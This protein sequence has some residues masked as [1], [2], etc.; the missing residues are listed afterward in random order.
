[1]R[2][3]VF[4]AC[5][6]AVSLSVP[7]SGQGL[8]VPPDSDVAH[9]RLPRPIRRRPPTPPPSSYK[10]K[11]ISINSRIQDQVARTQ[12]TQKFVNTGSRQ[13]E[14]S[15][16]FPLPYDGAVDQLTLMVDGQEYPARLMPAVLR[17]AVQR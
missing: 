12:V 6:F 3:R 11:E 8:L 1:M 17:R 2:F 10:I 7:A 16:V 4:L 15:F 14:V 9:W 13:M 5:L